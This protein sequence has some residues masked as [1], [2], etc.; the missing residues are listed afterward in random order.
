MWSTPKG[1][2][3]IL[4]SGVL[5]CITSI[6]YFILASVAKVVILTLTPYDTLFASLDQVY[7]GHSVVDSVLKN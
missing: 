1:L 5:S 2:L 7:H 3:G 4:G 6:C